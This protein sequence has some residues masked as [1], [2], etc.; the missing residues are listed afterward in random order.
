VHSVKYKNYNYNYFSQLQPHNSVHFHFAF[1]HTHLPPQRLEFLQLHFTNSVH[2]FEATGRV[3]HI[4]DH[5]W[6]SSNV[7]PKCC[8]LGI[9]TLSMSCT[10]APNTCLIDDSLTMPIDDSFTMLQECILSWW[11]WFHCPILSLFEPHWWIP[12]CLSCH[13]WQYNTALEA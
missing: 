8:G 11:N 6:S 1:L 7:H 2:A 4:G 3:I 13:T 5:F 12:G 9:L 10:N